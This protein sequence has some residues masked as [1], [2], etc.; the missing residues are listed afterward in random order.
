MIDDNA[1]INHLDS[2][3]IVPALERGLR[4]LGEFNRS[5]QIVAPPELARRLGLSRSTV[6][7]LLV[8]LESLGFVE[9]SK[10]GNEF[11]LGLAVL[12]L[13]FEY[14]ASLPLNELGRPLLRRLSE[15]IGYPCNIVVRDGRFIVYVTRVSPQ[16]QASPFVSSVNVGTRLPAHATVLGRM[17]LA[18][19]NLLRLEDLYP[20][21]DLESFSEHTPKTVISLYS[22]VC[23][24]FE[25]G[26]A[27]GEGFYEP[28][29]SSIAAPIFDQTGHIVAA[30][31][32]TINAGRFKD[33]QL[34]ADRVEQIVDS[35][36]R[37]AAEL[38][39]L[40]NYSS[41]LAVV[42]SERA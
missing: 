41:H 1:Y 37:T 12:R 17:L 22:M 35:V 42:E 38:S 4:V 34:D 11:R 28:S 20:E 29:I 3:Y 14:L 33:A 7:R 40:L 36:R 10:S 21:F 8:T 16:S 32:V 26:Y 5:N 2:P 18:D 19:L 39:R 6:F 25:K 9:R 23:N 30:M 31:G 13:G 27:I 24:D 15:E